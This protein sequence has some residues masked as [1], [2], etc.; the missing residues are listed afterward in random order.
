MFQMRIADLLIEVHHRYSYVEKQCEDWKCRE[1]VSRPDI[2]AEASEEEIRKEQE[3]FPGDI[4]AGYCESICIYRA[5]AKKLIDYSAFVMHGAVVELDGNA[6][7][8]A[9]KSGVGK[10]THTRLWIEYFRGRARYING[11]KPVMR[12]K[13]GIL[14]ACGTPWMGKENYGCNAYA[15]VKAF[16]FLERA[17][18]NQIQR[19][20]DQE[21]VER[22][23]HQVLLPEKPEEVITFMDFMD[24]MVRTIP[25]YILKCNISAD[26]AE[27][28]YNTMKEE[29]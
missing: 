27:L 24:T 5:I 23:F 22:L 21:I 13:D 25:F 2:T 7:V 11:D 14:Y 1:I 6:Y 17:K 28:A 26:A 20:S 18:E 16:C 15:P 8:F 12:W 4:S 9:A 10:T 19:A 3:D 29:R